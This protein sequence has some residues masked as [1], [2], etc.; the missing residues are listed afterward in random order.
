MSSLASGRTWRTH[1]HRPQLSADKALAV[2]IVGIALAPLVYLVYRSLQGGEQVL[3]ALSHPRTA[4]LVLRS[5]ALAGVVALSS[6]ILAFPLAWLTERAL[7]P[8]RRILLILWTLPLA[9]PSYLFAYAVV[10]TFGPRGALAQRM[11]DLL[12]LEQLPPLYG[13]GGAWF[14]LTMITFPYSY[15]TLRAAITRLDPSYE[16]AA[17]TLGVSSLEIHRRLTVPLLRPALAASF[18][19]SALYTLGDFGAI[20]VLRYP[21]LTYS[22]YNQYRLSFDRSAAAVLALLLV[23]LTTL[24]VLLE[25]HWQRQA[26][27]YR[28]TG[29]PRTSQHQR[30]PLWGWFVLGF[31]ALWGLTAVGL[32][33]GVALFWFLRALQLGESFPSVWEPLRNSLTVGALAALLTTLAAIPVARVLTRES[34]SWAG[35]LLDLP[36]WIS[37]SLPGIVLALALVSLS[38]QV[39]PWLYQTLPLLLLG[40]TLRF[41]TEAVGSLR[42]VLLQQ[43]PRL[44]EAARTLGATSLVAWLRIQLPLSLSGISSAAALVFLTTI[45][46]LPVTLILSPIGFPTLATSVWNATAD[47][48][49]SHAALPTLLLLGLGVIPMSVLT[50]RI[51]STGEGRVQHD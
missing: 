36:L 46:E 14:V 15:L 38:V 17:R 47:A 1:V 24:L 26:V 28:V 37:Y 2:A 39:L 8:A 31:G 43:N 25:R 20:A 23:S 21:T 22:I 50:T 9:I 12:N 41:L 34:S 33:F 48:Y 4:Q 19:L 40:Y 5:I 7:F 30:P 16:E 49:W 10:A 35:R 18:L 3:T 29:T 42:A 27:L 51:T 44:E 45:K 6:V 13:F 32:P 11:S